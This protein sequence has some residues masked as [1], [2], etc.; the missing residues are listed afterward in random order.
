[1]TSCYEFIFV[2]LWRYINVKLL[3]LLFTLKVQFITVNALVEVPMTVVFFKSVPY[4]E[5]MP[6]IVLY[7]NAYVYAYLF[8]NYRALQMKLITNITTTT[9]PTTTKRQGSHFRSLTCLGYDIKLHPTILPLLY[10]LG[11]S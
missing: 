8:L 7:T 3:L 6:C 9:I 2:F 11:S 10:Q 5:K 4:N 1:M